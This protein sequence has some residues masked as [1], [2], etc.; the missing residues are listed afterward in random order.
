L[1]QAS[2]TVGQLQALQQSVKEWERRCA[3]LHEKTAAEQQLKA[4]KQRHTAHRTVNS[5]VLTAAV[6]NSAGAL[7]AALAA[8][9]ELA[10][11]ATQLPRGAPVG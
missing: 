9:Q 8:A 10:A 1:P 3:T 2:V 6:S 11:D 7:A 4:S 5:A